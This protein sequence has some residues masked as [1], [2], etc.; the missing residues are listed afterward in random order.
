M[1][2]K[3][4][5]L[6]DKKNKWIEIYLKNFNFELNNKFLFKITNNYKTIKKQDLVFVLSY[7]KILPDSFLKRNKLTLVVHSSKLPR[8]RGFAPLTYKVLQNSNIIFFSLFQV[9]KKVDSGNIFLRTKLKLNG[10]ELYDELR[11]KQA[12][13]ILNLIKKFLFKYPLIKSSVQSGKTNYNKRRYP[14]DSELDINKNIK[15]QF[16]LMR[17]S[18]NEKFPIFFYHK[19]VKYILKIFKDL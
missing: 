15:S 19:S 14:R 12:E 7:T 8:D 6:L 17:V 16:N 13:T 4:T 11:K 3:A 10:T 18:D 1:K 5:F 9:V 2:Y